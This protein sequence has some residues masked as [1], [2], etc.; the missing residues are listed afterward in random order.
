L[1]YARFEAEIAR[2]NDVLCAINLLDWDANTVMPASGTQ[3]R[4]HQIATLTGLAASILSSESLR[5]AIDDA[6][7]EIA[8]APPDDYRRRAL[9]Q[10]KAAV[11]ILSRVPGRLLSD[12][13]ELR[14]NAQQ[15]WAEARRQSDFSRFAPFLERTFAL[16]REL[17]KAIGYSKHPYDALIERYDPG[18]TLARVR[19]LFDRL[20]AGLGPLI[21]RAGSLPKPRRDFLVRPYPIDRQRAF[22]RDIA[23]RMGFDFDRGRLDDT[24]HP[25]ESAITRNDVRL[26]G[27]FGEASVVQGLF[28][29]WHEA[30]HGM[31]EQGTDPGLAR[32]ALTADLINLAATGGASFGMHESQS[33][34]WENRV[35][36]SRR[37]WELHF[38]ELR[39]VFPEQLA[40]VSAEEFW[41]A[42][43]IVEPGLIR[44]E[45][46]ELTYDFHIMLRTE[47]EADL[48]NG[49]VTVA[50]LPTIW[51]ERMRDHLGVEVP[52][53]RRGVLQDVHWSAGM[54]GGFASYT[55]GNVVAS[56]LM[57][58]AASESAVQGGLERGDYAPLLSWLNCHVHRHA[59]GRRAD[60]ILKEAT[61]S[62]L[63]PG[64]YLAYL[65]SRYS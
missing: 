51:R 32:S 64:P 47:I 44:V 55:I 38:E 3:T 58:A 48:L 23:T 16:Q 25:F 7:E 35:G 11:D 39:S 17:A 56:Q 41:R 61:G 12:I 15:A 5:A 14:T 60:E 65:G 10:T 28:A 22:A 1:G 26:A 13:A 53:D 18:M 2:V 29:V 34:L 30:G 19:D 54:V 36:R 59:R 52:D 24:V 57:A 43:N 21:A 33:R 49:D 20:K 31:Y 9:E 63:D 27:R 4:G 45:A 8:A 42:V 46:D 50:D 40:D 6:S 37:F 62:T